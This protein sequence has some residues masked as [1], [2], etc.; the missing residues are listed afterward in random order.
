MYCYHILLYIFSFIA[1]NLDALIN[2][3]YSMFLIINRIFSQVIVIIFFIIDL[4]CLLLF[5]MRYAL[6]IADDGV[7]VPDVTYCMC[8]IEERHC[9]AVVADDWELITFSGF[10]HISY[11]YSCCC[12]GCGCSK[13]K[14]CE[15][16]A[17][18]KFW[19]NTPVRYLVCVNICTT[20]VN[21][22]CPIW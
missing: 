2:V 12:C 1:H 17:D 18:S 6:W 5:L 21:G 7:H 11:D 16:S 4:L 15:E 20:C 14:Q 19:L 9:R 13:I 3:E 22:T 10:G 8:L